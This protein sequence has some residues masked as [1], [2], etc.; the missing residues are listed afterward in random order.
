M[1]YTNICLIFVKLVWP[2]STQPIEKHHILY[3]VD[4]A[5]FWRFGHNFVISFS[6]QESLPPILQLH[7]KSNEI[8]SSK[9]CLYLKLKIRLLNFRWETKFVW[10]QSHIDTTGNELPDPLEQF[11]M[12]TQMLSLG[13]W[14]T[15]TYI[16]KK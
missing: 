2:Y 15:H 3:F 16:F 10:T 9:I 7:A 6:W 1:V 14:P 8:T 11:H 12:I 13:E 4:V 5:S